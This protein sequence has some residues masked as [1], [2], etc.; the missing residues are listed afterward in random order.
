MR[1]LPVLFLAAAAIY[2]AGSGNFFSSS[3]ISIAQAATKLGDL[4]KFKKIAVDTNELVKKGDLAGAKARI[5]D[6]ESTWDDAESGI[7]P[8]AGSD[9]RALDKAIDRALD[10]LRDSTPSAE[11]CKKAMSDLL[12][13]FAR[14]EK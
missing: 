7:K 6:L 11:A 9:W 2:L 4:S 1:I 12:D 8:R 3:P 5:K 13:T 10:A 14:L